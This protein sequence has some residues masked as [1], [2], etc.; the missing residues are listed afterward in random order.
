MEEF[1]QDESI[2]VFLLH[3]ERER[4]VISHVTDVIG[5]FADGPIVRV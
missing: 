3:A 2:K 5:P 1:Q 4:Y